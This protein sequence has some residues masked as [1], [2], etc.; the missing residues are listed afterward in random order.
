MICS[1]PMGTDIRVTG[2]IHFLLFILH[3]VLRQSAPVISASGLF[4]IKS[5]IVV[6]QFWYHKYEEKRGVAAF[7]PAIQIFDVR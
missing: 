6:P 2:W 4:I 7:A 5:V 3:V 1:Y